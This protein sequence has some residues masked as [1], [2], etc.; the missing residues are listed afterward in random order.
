MEYRNYVK[1]WSFVTPGWIGTYHI[2]SLRKN[3]KVI[4]GEDWKDAQAKIEINSSPYFA[5]TKSN[6]KLWAKFSIT[7]EYYDSV[8]RIETWGFGEKGTRKKEILT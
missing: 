3:S 1:F 6:V 2:F 8:G 4:H 5:A 7:A